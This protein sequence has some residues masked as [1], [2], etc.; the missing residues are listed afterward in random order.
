MIS[1]TLGEDGVSQHSQGHHMAQCLAIQTGVK[2]KGSGRGL[3]TYWDS[4]HCHG[5]HKDV[6]FIL[7]PISLLPT[8]L[9][10]WSG[11]RGTAGCLELIL[12]TCSK[13][14]PSMLEGGIIWDATL[15][16][17]AAICKASQVSYTL[18]YL[19]GSKNFK[20]D[21]TVWLYLNS[22]V[23]TVDARVSP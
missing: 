9:K 10:H 16:L 7:A 1:K 20:L 22:I 5:Y 19:P 11:E 14:T 17:R 18:Y 8:T 23:N 2:P 21:V 3:L 15:K 6:I 4:N 12:G 13:I